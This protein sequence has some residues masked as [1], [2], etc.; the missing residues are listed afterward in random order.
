MGRDRGLKL[1]I[2]I[3]CTGL[4]STMIAQNHFESLGIGAAIC[5]S[6]IVIG[7]NVAAM[8]DKSTITGGKVATSSGIG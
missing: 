4:G 8:D 2:P 5:G 7:E 6:G 1:R 3:I